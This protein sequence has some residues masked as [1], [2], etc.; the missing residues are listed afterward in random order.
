[1][2]IMFCL[3]TS[4]LSRSLRG[5]NQSKPRLALALIVDDL[6]IGRRDLESAYPP[7]ERPSAIPLVQVQRVSRGFERHGIFISPFELVV[8]ETVSTGYDLPLYG[9]GGAPSGPLNSSLQ[10]SFQCCGA[11]FDVL[12][13][14]PDVSRPH[15]TIAVKKRD[16][17]IL[18]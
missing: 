5:L 8:A 16:I 14:A 13:E 15:A 17:L 11:A 1:M 9:S 12:L 7:N 3:S 6:V 4:G 10:L 2:Y 18:C